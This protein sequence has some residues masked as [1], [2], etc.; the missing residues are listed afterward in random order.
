AAR[1]GAD[2]GRACLPPARPGPHDGAE[3]AGLPRLCA[4]LHGAA[5]EAERQMMGKVLGLRWWTIALIMLGAILN[6]LTRTT[7]SVAAPTMMG[8]LHISTAEYSYITGAFQVAIMF[9]PIVG[10]VLDVIGLKL[11]L[12][13]FAAAWSLICM[14][15]GLAHS[16]QGFAALRAAL[17]FA[18]GS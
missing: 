9:Q 12:A 11:G 4:A 2:H 17:G 8:E 3:L 13:I 16:W 15:H 7:L 18:E 1:Q 14:A 10:Y 6:F 5:A